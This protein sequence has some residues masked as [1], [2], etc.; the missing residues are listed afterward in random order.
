MPT[1]DTP[2]RVNFQTEA[3]AFQAADDYCNA[4][5]D[6]Q[7]AGQFTIYAMYP[8]CG[9][10][11]SRMIIEDV[12]DFAAPLLST[13]RAEPREHLWIA[14][15]VQYE[16]GAYGRYQ[17]FLI[18]SYIPTPVEEIYARARQSHLSDEPRFEA[19]PYPIDE[20]HHSE[21]LAVSSQEKA[22]ASPEG[23]VRRKHS[24]GSW[25]TAA[26]FGP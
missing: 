11:A 25:S 7:E 12:S 10:C 6:Q 16:P 14:V 8:V 15:C 21:R 26:I 22:Q 19:Y 23:E 20:T 13:V 4:L 5:A 2:L 17:P 1:S 3:E 9:E 24:D 18:Y